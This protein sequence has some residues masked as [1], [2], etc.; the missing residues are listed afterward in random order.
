MDWKRRLQ[1]DESILKALV[2]RLSGPADGDQP[3]G[4]E[5]ARRHLAGKLAEMG[6]FVEDCLSGRT[7][8]EQAVL[9]YRLRIECPLYAHLASLSSMSPEY[10][11]FSVTA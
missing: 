1:Y 3:D 9:L 7:E 2:D 6:A 11:E 8:S 10:A 4:R 5:L